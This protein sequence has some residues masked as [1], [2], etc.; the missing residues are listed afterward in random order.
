MEVL[1]LK[2]LEVNIIWHKSSILYNCE[3]RFVGQDIVPEKEKAGE[4]SH[5]SNADFCGTHDT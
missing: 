5:R 1:I 2:G 4:V 3:A